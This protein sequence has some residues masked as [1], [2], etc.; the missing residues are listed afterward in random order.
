MAAIAAQRAVRRAGLPARGLRRLRLDPRPRGRG[1]ALRV[2]RAAAEARARPGVASVIPPRYRGVSFDRPP[3]SDMARD[4]ATKEPSTTCATS[5]TSSTSGSG[6]G[7][8]LVAVR[9]HRDR[10]DDAGDAGL[11]G[12]ARG[13]A[14]PSPI[15]SL[16]KLLARIRRTYELRA[17][18]RLLPLLLRAAHLGRSPPHRR[19]RR[20]EAHRLGAGA[21][22][23]AGQRALRGAAIDDG[24]H[25]PPTSRSWRS[26]S[27]RA[28]SPG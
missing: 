18:R 9:R 1:A 28:P 5:S 2:P 12:G 17:G 8:G 16:P 20:G 10:Q 15:Y 3:V 25:Q 7:R 13:R 11:E 27:A 4:L 14:T 21:A 24:H 6:A 19:P 22:L 23:R 26:R